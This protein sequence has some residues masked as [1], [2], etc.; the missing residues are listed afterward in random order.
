MW[1]IQ[2]LTHET[3]KPF[4][5]QTKNSY[6]LF[7]IAYLLFNRLLALFYAQHNK[8]DNYKSV[9]LTY[10]TRKNMWIIQI[11]THEIHKMIDILSYKLC[12]T[13]GG[14]L[15]RV[16]FN[17][18]SNLRQNNL[19]SRH[20]RKVPS[21]KEEAQICSKTNPFLCTPTILW[22]HHSE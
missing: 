9:S 4:G 2:I 10:G 13:V 18:I 6:Y 15:K 3:L 12:L 14:C 20:E 16:E 7:I 8:K 21:L 22:Q 1:I 19:V 17:W 11:L 5:V